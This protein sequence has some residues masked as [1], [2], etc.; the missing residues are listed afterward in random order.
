VVSVSELTISQGEILV[1]L[2]ITA[3]LCGVIGF[4]RETRDQSVGFRTNFG[5]LKVAFSD[6]GS[7]INEVTETL[8][9]HGVQIRSLGAE[10]EKGR[11][12][13]TA[14]KCTAENRC[15]PAAG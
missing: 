3:A 1:R 11:S 15:S 7:G 5:V 4:E 13:Y 12:R 2:L 10:I 14:P 8:E 6:V 9:R